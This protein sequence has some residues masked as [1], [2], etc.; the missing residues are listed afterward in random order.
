MAIAAYNVAKN[1]TGIYVLFLSL[2]AIYAVARVL[3]VLPGRIPMAAVVALHVLPPIVFALIH[4]SGLYR[5]RGILMFFAICLVIGNI[6]EIPTRQKNSWVS[7]GWGS[8]PSE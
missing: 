4:G 2:I 7:S 6:V 3:Q 5:T 8:L 1:K